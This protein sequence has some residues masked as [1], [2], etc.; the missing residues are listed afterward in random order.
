MTPT[1]DDI[2]LAVQRVK[3]VGVLDIK[4]SLGAPHVREARLLAYF[5]ASQCFNKSH[6]VIGKAVNR[7]EATVGEAIRRL[8]R[9]TRFHPELV[10][11]VEDEVSRILEAKRAT[12]AA[13]EAR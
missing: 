10:D 13:L 6:V 3:R 5:V 9:Q 7:S 11:A 4:G 1:M 12:F 8:T 2:L